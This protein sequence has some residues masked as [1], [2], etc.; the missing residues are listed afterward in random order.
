[1]DGLNQIKWIAFSPLI[2][3]L[4]VPLES[5][6]NSRKTSEKIKNET[7]LYA[8]SSL[9]IEKITRTFLTIGNIFRQIFEGVSTI[10][11]RE[12]GLIWA[13]IFLILL[14]TLFKGLS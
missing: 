10:L 4:L 14:L 8:P 11:E 3:L 12:G 6:V 5:I 9:L 1:M 13:I 7:T 2:F